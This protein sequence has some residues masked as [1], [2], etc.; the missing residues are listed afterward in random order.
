MPATKG[1]RIMNEYLSTNEGLLNTAF[2]IYVPVLV[3]LIVLVRPYII[4]SLQ[5]IIHI[6]LMIMIIESKSIQRNCSALS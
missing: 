6:M 1:S 4:C 5:Y 3:F 2:F